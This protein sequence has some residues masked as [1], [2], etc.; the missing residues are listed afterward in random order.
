MNLCAPTFSG[1]EFCH[2]S[3][4]KRIRR[5]ATVSGSG[6]RK[7]SELTSALQRFSAAPPA[8]LTEIAQCPARIHAKS[9]NMLR[10]ASRAVPRSICR[11]PT[12][13]RLRQASTDTAQRRF[14]VYQSQTTKPVVYASLGL[15]ALFGWTAAI[16]MVGGQGEKKHAATHAIKKGE[17]LLIRSCRTPP[18]I[19]NSTHLCA[20]S[21]TVVVESRDRFCRHLRTP[22]A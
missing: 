16:L 3:N 15:A 20:L 7:Y 10:S 22:W 13:A 11:S 5:E 14:A 8:D 17:Q 6:R 9:V 21:T 1:N 19:T 12:A 4:Q 2:H 18:A